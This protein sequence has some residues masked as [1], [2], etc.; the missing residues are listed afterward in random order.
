MNRGPVPKSQPSGLSFEDKV[1][2]AYPETSD[3]LIELARTADAEGLA[4][5]ERRIGYSK[6]AISF[7][8]NGKYVGDLDRVAAMVRGAL[9]AETVLCPVLDEIG[10]DRCLS[11]QS[12][13]FRA[14]SK[15]R[16]QLYHAC[17]SGCRH[18][19]LK[20]REG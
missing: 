12:E 8:L 19:N 7:V 5:A 6:S 20:K 13:P 11:E 10:R 15:H 4:G 2:A 3:W 18:S 16:S 14:T 9:M 17:R 1:R